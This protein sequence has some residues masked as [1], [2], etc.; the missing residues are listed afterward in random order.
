MPRLMISGNKK[1]RNNFRLHPTMFGYEKNM[2]SLWI[3]RRKAWNSSISSGE[4]QG[5]VGSSLFDTLL[6]DA[7]WKI[8]RLNSIHLLLIWGTYNITHT[9]TSYTFRLKAERFHSPAFQAKENVYCEWSYI[10]KTS[11]S[12][13]SSPLRPKFG[14]LLDSHS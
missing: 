7:W 3:L 10:L 5:I 11:P 6:G 1:V 4:N 2:D 12:L 13:W 9:H 14:N 8:N